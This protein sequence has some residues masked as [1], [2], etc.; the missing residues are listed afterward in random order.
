MTQLTLLIDEV[1]D[2][3]KGKAPSS[4]FHGFW[5]VKLLGELNIKKTKL[6]I[7]PVFVKKIGFEI[8]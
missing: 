7:E 1:G 4:P 5:R 2:F 6:N 3:S 8:W